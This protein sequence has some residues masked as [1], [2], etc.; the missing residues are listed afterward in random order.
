[1]KDFSGKE[2]KVGSLVRHAYEPWPANKA[3]ERGLGYHYHHFSGT[4]EVVEMVGENCVRVFSAV[5][6]IPVYL[7]C[8]LEVVP[9]TAYAVTRPYLNE[10]PAAYKP[11]QAA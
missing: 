3:G 1:M 4:A 8:L 10:L 5:R 6:M 7:G 11:K 9:D 2:I